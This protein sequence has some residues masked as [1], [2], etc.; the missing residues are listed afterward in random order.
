MEVDDSVLMNDSQILYT[1]D[2]EPSRSE[3]E[4]QDMLSSVDKLITYTQKHE[5][6]SD[7]N[8]LYIF[9]YKLI[10]KN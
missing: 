1:D 3:N 7:Y 5:M 10:N 4:K 8:N 9:K 6:K 2:A